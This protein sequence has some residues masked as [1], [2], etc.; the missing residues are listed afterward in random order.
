MISTLMLMKSCRAVLSLGLTSD[1]LHDRVANALNA[2]CVAIVEDTPLHRRLFRHGE[3]ALLFRY[4]D[5]SLADC[6]D[7]VCYEPERACAIAQAG[8]ALR[9]DPAIRFGQFDR[10]LDLIRR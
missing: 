3:T 4:D 5:G 7:L 9:D 6:L 10:L 2:G 1:M 8:F